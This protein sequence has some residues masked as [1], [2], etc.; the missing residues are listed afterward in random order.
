[1][2][3]VFCERWLTD[4]DVCMCMLQEMWF[5]AGRHHTSLLTKECRVQ[6]NVIVDSYTSYWP[7][8]TDELI[9]M[10]LPAVIVCLF[11]RVVGVVTDGVYS[12][13]SGCRCTIVKRQRDRT[14]TAASEQ[15]VTPGRKVVCQR[16][17]P[18][19]TSVSQIP[20]DSLPQNTLHL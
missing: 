10:K 4:N 5:T 15:S 13:P 12:C 7:C 2:S 8:Y 16:T 18:L 11:L 19:I 20:L 3:S 9:S 1:M 14:T 6:S 17:S